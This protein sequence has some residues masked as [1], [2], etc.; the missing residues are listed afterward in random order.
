MGSFLRI[1]RWTMEALWPARLEC[2]ALEKIG[3]SVTPVVMSNRRHRPGSRCARPR[4]HQ[5]PP[6]STSDALRVHRLPCCGRRI[7]PG[8]SR[9]TPAATGTGVRT[10]PR[11]LGAKIVDQLAHEILFNGGAITAVAPTGT[12]RSGRARKRS[13]RQQLSSNLCRRYWG[14]SRSP[15]C[16]PRES[17]PLRPAARQASQSVWMECSR[18]C[19][20]RETCQIGFCTIILIMFIQLSP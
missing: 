6:T 14:A 13:V 11:V 12:S 16:P 19:S 9:R 4:D 10:A 17:P 3:C 8:I 5:P 18:L 20:E 15:G 7:C 2:L 1:S